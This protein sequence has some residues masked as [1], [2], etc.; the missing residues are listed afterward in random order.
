M[1]IIVYHGYY[2]CDTG[3]CGH[4]IIVEDGEVP[5]GANDGMTFEHPYKQ[6]PKAWARKLLLSE[7]FSEE[8]LADIDWD[9][10]LFVDD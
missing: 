10:C 2:G 7:G 6:D 9:N 1:R 3:C 4:Y 8:H 5:D